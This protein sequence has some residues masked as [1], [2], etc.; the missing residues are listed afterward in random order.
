VHRRRLVSFLGFVAV[1]VPVGAAAGTSTGSAN[2][3]LSP[4]QGP[5]GTHF[6]A[7]F[8]YSVPTCQEYS[9]DFGWDNNTYLGSASD[10]SSGQSCKVTL[11]AVVPSSASAATHTVTALAHPRGTA[12]GAGPGPSATASF[13]V[14]QPAAGS[15]TS[16]GT[17]TTL[18]VARS[19]STTWSSATTVT[20]ATTDPQSPAGPDA[21]LAQGNLPADGSSSTSSAA[22]SLNGDATVPLATAP[23]AATGGSGW[24]IPL[25]VVLLVSVSGCGVIVMRRRG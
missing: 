9:V 17:S 23:P 3:S 13:R 7:T 5:V 10:G 20:T 8:V 18:S 1:L 19:T 25:V 11:Q 4:A 22:Q 12:V 24:L 2:L 16:Q 15:T 21:A 6:A 14:T